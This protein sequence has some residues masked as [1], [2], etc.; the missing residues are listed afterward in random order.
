M[1]NFTNIVNTSYA[2]LDVVSRS[3]VGFLPAALR[4]IRTDMVA[5]GDTVNVPVSARGAI[6]DIAPG[7][8]GPNPAG[9][10]FVNTPVVIDNFKTYNFVL[11]GED[12]AATNAAGLG[13]TYTR[14]QIAYGFETLIADVESNLANA[15]YVNSSRAIGTAATTPFGTA[16]NLTD[17]SNLVRVLNEEGAPAANRRLVLSNSAA[18]NLRGIQSTLFNV[19]QAGTDQGLREGAIGRLHGFA[20]GESNFAPSHTKGTG[21]GYLVNVTATLP[22]GTTQIPLDTGTGTV[23]AGD[24]VTFTGDTTKYVVTSGITA[25]GTITIGGS[26]L[27]QTLANNVAMTIGNDYNVA[28]VAFTPDSLLLA[29]RRPYLPD[30]GD[31]AT[32]STE[33]QDP[34]SGLLFRL[35]EYK[36]NHRTVYTVELAYGVKALNSRHSALLLG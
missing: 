31:M 22:V 2:A 11:N 25:P 28:G 1:P 4:D 16:N 36:Q 20:V 13:D 15:I 8:N 23:V 12:N 18:A 10:D 35:A 9:V 14:Q 34:V 32:N 21:S 3:I 7:V 33:I 5:Q 26:G 6:A 19:N 24:I 17:T 27:R 30:G 29:A